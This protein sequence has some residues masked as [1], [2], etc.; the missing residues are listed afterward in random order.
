MSILAAIRREE[1][2]VR[3]QLQRLQNQ[4]SGL[5]AAANALGNSAGQ[6]LTGVKKRVLSKAG[7]AKIAKAARKRW[8]KIRAQAKKVTN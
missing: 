7:R 6:E 4:L 5:Q 8:A 2:K 1:K 3:K